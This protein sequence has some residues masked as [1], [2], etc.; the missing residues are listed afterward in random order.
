M[1][2]SAQS[3]A[4]GLHALK[5]KKEK[6]NVELKRGHCVFVIIFWLN[7]YYSCLSIWVEKKEIKKTKLKIECASE[8]VTPAFSNAADGDGIW[9]G[10]A[11]YANCLSLV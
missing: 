1:D 8:R 6:I 4:V 2:R 9:L 10:G 11:N 5:K 7:H 3:L